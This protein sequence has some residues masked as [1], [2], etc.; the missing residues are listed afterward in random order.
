MADSEKYALAQR[1]DTLIDE[2]D[3]TIQ[4]IQEKFGLYVLDWRVEDNVYQ[5]LKNFAEVLL[6]AYKP[7]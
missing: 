1:F 5:N 3:Q 7:F 4:E 6:K 2:L